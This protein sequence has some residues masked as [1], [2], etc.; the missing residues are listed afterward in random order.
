[1]R[2]TPDT[3]NPGARATFGLVHG[4]SSRMSFLIR[5][6][7]T[8]R[9]ELP[10]VCNHAFCVRAD[11]V[12]IV[13]SVPSGTREGEWR[14]LYDRPEHWGVLVQPLGLT[15]VDLQSFQQELDAYLGARYGFAALAKHFVDGVLG[16]LAGRDVYL[17]R[18]LRLP[19]REG[20]PRYNICSWLVCWT[21]KHVGWR[22]HGA[23]GE[24]PCG[25]VA[26]DD[27]WDDVFEHRPG[28][29]R[30]VR[31]FGR[32]PQDLRRRFTKIL[33]SKQAS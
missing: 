9:G 19:W 12:T 25:R 24:L 33:D 16:R 23:A 5:L 4:R 7:S 20:A 15:Q 17:L 1:M 32:R 10:S 31:E 28:S 11:G 22:F 6:F 30:V 13:E 8:F 26:P 18:R 3:R 29:Y 21:H 27:L 2:D 14:A